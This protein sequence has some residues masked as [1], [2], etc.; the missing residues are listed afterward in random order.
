MKGL[1][2]GYLVAIFTLVPASLW[3][4]GLCVGNLV[5]DFAD[6]VLEPRWV[7]TDLVCGSV[8][9]TAGSLRLDRG[10][11]VGVL[12]VVMNDQVETLCG[13][14]DVSV[15]FALTGFTVPAVGS[16]WASFGARTTDRTTLA[17]IER[18]NTTAPYLC[19]PDPSNYKMYVN[20]PHDN[21]ASTLVATSDQAG[22][23]RLRR[24]GALLEFYVWSGGWQ[25]LATRPFP[26]TD[27]T[28]VFYAGTDF[29]ANA[30]SVSFDNLAIRSAVLISNLSEDFS[31]GILN[32]IWLPTTSCGTPVVSNGELVLAKNDG[33]TDGPYVTQDPSVSIIRGD[34]DVS[35]SFS[36]PSFAVPP[37]QN[38]A[39]ARWFS[40]QV[41][42][43]SNMSP[44]SFTAAIQV[45]SRQVG[46]CATFGRN[47]KAFTSNPLNCI[48]SWADASGDD[49][50]KLRI[51]RIG[52]TLRMYFWN[53]KWNNWQLLRSEVGSTA[54][55]VVRLNSCTGVATGAHDGRFDNI[56]IYD[57][58]VDVGE[59]WPTHGFVLEVHPNPFNPSTTISYSIA[60]EGWVRLNIYDVRGALVRALVDGN[61]PAGRQA[62]TWDGSNSRGVLASSGI[63]F[64]RLASGGR[65]MA[66]KIALL[67]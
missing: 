28:L 64:V 2:I 21:C 18:Y 39:G 42:P 10:S 4:D 3:A 50:G 37:V 46:D 56:I 8:G 45:Y 34:F 41:H 33:C 51:T 16:R 22:K 66:R 27:V 7:V 44:G 12:G 47:Y 14:F 36:L 40:L 61:Q 23:F 35:A 6:G 57:S 67:K 53:K 48:S 5:E 52:D 49:A 15:D 11:C 60:S 38:P 43:V 55:V 31:D 32:S 65:S 26:T 29:D 54:D 20:T 1:A 58:P 9:E 59:N 25:I 63:Y 24:V 62:V 30:F 17:I 13:D 19:T